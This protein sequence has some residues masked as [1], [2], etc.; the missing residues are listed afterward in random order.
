MS[1]YKYCLDL[2][3]KSWML[4]FI[5]LFVNNFGKWEIITEEFIDISL[6]FIKDCLKNKDNSN[7]SRILNY[8]LKLT[9]ENENVFQP[10]FYIF[11]NNLETVADL[12]TNKLD[13]FIIFNYFEVIS[14]I[15][16][17]FRVSNSDADPI[18]IENLISKLFRFTYLDLDKS[19]YTEWLEPANLFENS[20]DVENNLQSGMNSFDNIFY[21]FSHKKY[22]LVYFKVFFDYSIQNIDEDWRM[23]YTSNMI[24]S[25]ISE[26]LN[27]FETM[28]YF[29]DV[30]FILI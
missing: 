19:I 11:C 7:C 27:N 26:F 23:L 25:H 14:S 15:A 16:R 4:K 24:L 6:N 3:T 10:F 1:T 17:S 21:S 5:L 9:Q 22:S 13:N 2:G 29:L 18:A 20:E 8:L 28:G 12:I 30:I